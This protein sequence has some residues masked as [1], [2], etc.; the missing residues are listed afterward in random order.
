MNGSAIKSNLKA[1]FLSQGI[2]MLLSVITALV[3]PKVLGVEEFGYWQ[4]FIFYMSYTPYAL[5]GIADGVYLINGGKSRNELDKRSTSSQFLCD[6]IVQLIAF[7]AI[8]YYAFTLGPLDSR[9]FVFVG[10]ALML[11]LQCSVN[12]LCWI[13]QAINETK[14]YSYALIVNRLSFLA[15]LI[16]LLLFQVRDFRY[17]LL[18]FTAAQ[19][20]MLGYCLSFGKDF[21]FQRPYSPCVSIRYSIR[22]LTV[23]LVLSIAMG[24]STL[25]LGVVRFFVDCTQSIEVFSLVSLAISLTTFVLRFIGQV[26]MVLFPALRQADGNERV[27]FYEASKA[28]LELF[29]PVVLLLYYPAALLVSLWLPDYSASVQLFAYLIPIC[30]FEGKMQIVYAT[31]FKVFRKEKILLYVNCLGIAISA[32]GAFFS[33]YILS[34][35]SL[36][37][38]FLTIAYVVRSLFAEIYLNMQFELKMSGRAMGEIALTAFFLVCVSLLSSGLSFAVTLLSYI[39]F[40]AFNRKAIRKL[41][42]ISKSTGT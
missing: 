41:F 26:G 27:L 5:L 2:S 12:Y 39:A 22:S 14:R 17:Y 40:L 16:P 1:A 36:S 3:V 34:S 38:L 20:I 4:L 23:G 6:L 10:V 18:A 29:L 8:L 13:F 31:F 15:M 19:V 25:S 33:L 11:I 28:A 21:I 42:L 37:L 24:A 30:I 32:V 35:V 9:F 7:A